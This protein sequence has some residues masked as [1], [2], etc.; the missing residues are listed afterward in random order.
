MKNIVIVSA[1]RTAVGSFQGSLAALLAPTLG[2]AVIRAILDE[3]RVGADRVDQ[4]IMG[5]VLIAGVGQNPA[6]QAA[7]AAGIPDKVP[8]QT[9]NVVCGSGLRSVHLAA[10][11]IMAGESQIVIAGGQENM[12]QSPYLLPKAREGYR[13]GDQQVIDSMVF[14]G[15]TDIYNR[16]HMGITAE[17]VAERFKISREDQDRLALRS[18]ERASAAH[19]AG[20]FKDEIVPVSIPQRKGDPKIFDHDEYIKHDATAEGLAKL[21]PAF[22]RDGGTVTAGNA[23]GINDGAAAVMLMSESKAK[24]LGLKILARIEATGMTGVEP[25]IMGVGPIGAS[26]QALER[27]GWKVSD[28]DLVE[29]NEA[30]AAQAAAVNN[31]VGFDPEKVNVNGGAIAIGHPI[32][33]S[34]CRILVTLLHEMNRRDAKKGLATLCVGGGMGVAL[35]VSR[36]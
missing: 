16:Y 14:D 25:E 7:R 35:L 23:S 29:A 24:E 5:N 1:K 21:R 6:R 32:G 30:F 31:G 3:T 4:V 33:A 36:D 11:S 34:G 28:L 12:S 17:N 15:L 10:Q 8:S 2:G 13:M 22:K 18:Q 27:A 9:I 19:K 20:K 26:K